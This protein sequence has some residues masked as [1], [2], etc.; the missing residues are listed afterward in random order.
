MI[1]KVKYILNHSYRLYATSPRTKFLDKTGT[2]YV[3]YYLKYTTATVDVFFTDDPSCVETNLR[4]MGF[5]KVAGSWYKPAQKKTYVEVDVRG[6]EVDVKV[7]TKRKVTRMPL[8]F[9]APKD[10]DPEDLL[11]KAFSIVEQC[12]FNEL[13]VADM[14]KRIGDANDTYLRGVMRNVLVSYYHTMWLASR[15]A[16]MKLRSV[17][18]AL[19]TYKGRNPNPQIS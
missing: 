9:V 17:P 18:Y 15:I 4:E 16:H 14:L 6:R 2:G 10:E 5:V 3:E 11:K 19:V 7:I 13:V 12:G 8:Y 1:T